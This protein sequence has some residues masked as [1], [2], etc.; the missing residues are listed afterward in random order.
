M[1]SKETI[2]LDSR[3]IKVL[4]H[5]LRMR[6]LA[7]LRLEGPSTATILADKTGESS[8]VTSYHLR[9][10][11]EVGLVS[12]KL[13]MGTRRERFWQASQQ[14]MSWRNSDHDQ[15][16]DARA[17]SDWLIRQLHRRYAHSVDQWLDARADW[18]AEWRDAA[19][20]SDFVVT[21]TPEELNELNRRVR[22]IYEEYNTDHPSENAEQVFLINYA[23]PRR[24]VEL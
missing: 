11:S 19:D 21:V 1:T 14:A 9:K 12:E 16:P 20:Q 24:A 18:P 15:E 13:E 7:L 23:V 6:L 4:A 22:E 8:G 5:P 2:H 3:T 10:L 17:A